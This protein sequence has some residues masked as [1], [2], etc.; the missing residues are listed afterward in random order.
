V[1]RLS[2]ATHSGVRF[3]RRA[4]PGRWFCVL[5][6]PPVLAAAADVGDP[7]LEVT[8]LFGIRGGATL[9]P[10]TVGAGSMEADASPSLGVAVDFLVRPDARMEIFL[11][12]QELDFDGDPASGTAP[13]DVTIDYL[14]AGGVY[15]PRAEGTRPFVAVDL[16]LTRVE[17]DG[18]T[19]DDSLALSGSIGG[20]AKVGIGDRLSLR[21]ELRGY[22]TFSDGT[23]QVACGPGC[24]VRLEAGGWYQLAAR[25]GLAVRIGGGPAGAPRVQGR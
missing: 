14:H 25:L 11:E 12:R 3:A 22:A 1:K 8:P 10:E 9:E 2:R 7:A 20:G 6:A 24:A 5:L 4:R 15:E 19:V 13:F 23:L 17:A 16:G 18:A 21:L